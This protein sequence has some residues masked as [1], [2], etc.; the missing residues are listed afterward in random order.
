MGGSCMKS[1][2]KNKNKNKDDQKNKPSEQDLTIARLKG[3]RDDLLDKRKAIEKS[4][5]KSEDEIKQ[6]LKMGK[7]DQAIFA[8]KRKKLYEEYIS[9]VNGKYQFA[10]SAIIEVDKA[11]MDRNLNQVLKDTNNLLQDIQKSVDMEEV[12]DYMNYLEEADQKR[13]EFNQLFDNYNINKSD[14]IDK[15]YDKYEAQIGILI[16]LYYFYELYY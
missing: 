12:H 13:N 7:K 1:N 8:L 5:D 9:Q 15:E 16:I 14:E 4:I 11:M 3:L 2:K 10:Q 6:L